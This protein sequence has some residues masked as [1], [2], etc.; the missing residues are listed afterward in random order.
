MGIPRPT[1]EEPA[2]GDGTDSREAH[3]PRPS[4]GPPSSELNGVFSSGFLS[5]YEPRA[6]HFL[7][8]QCPQRHDTG[9]P[10]HF[11]GGVTEDQGGSEEQPGSVCAAPPGRC[12]RP[13]PPQL[14]PE[15]KGL[16][17]D[18]VVTGRSAAP[19]VKLLAP[20]QT[21]ALCLTWVRTSRVSKYSR[22]PE[23]SHASQNRE[24]GAMGTLG[25]LPRAGVRELAELGQPLGSSMP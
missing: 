20:G 1:A 14:V 22:S 25:D 18:A 24:G 3:S 5:T 12:T 6:R 9:L 10:P 8:V 19:S 23:A 15:N 13:S 2:E 4:L 7:R 21:R 17:V 16:W 11:A